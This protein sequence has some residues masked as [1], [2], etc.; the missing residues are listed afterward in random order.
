MAAYVLGVLAVLGPATVSHW[1]SIGA[2]NERNAMKLPGPLPR[3]APVTSYG[4]FNFAIANHQHSDGGPNNDHP[5]LETA[6]H[7]EQ[8]LLAE[9]GLNLASPASSSSSTSTVIE[10]ASPGWRAIL[11]TRRR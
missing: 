7:E 8:D 6:I 10:S 2:F 5:V 11:R 9:G 1:R 4:A 3:F